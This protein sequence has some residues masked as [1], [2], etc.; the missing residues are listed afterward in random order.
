MPDLLF[1]TLIIS[2]LTGKKPVKFERE[3]EKMQIKL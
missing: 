3:N 1:K 2:N